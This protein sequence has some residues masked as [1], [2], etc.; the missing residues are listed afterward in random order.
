ML[1]LFLPLAVAHSPS[2][3]AIFCEAIGVMPNG[4]EVV[5]PSHEAL[6][7]AIERCFEHL[8]ALEALNAI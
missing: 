1:S 8:S 7:V 3:C 6:V 5:L 4:A 2:S